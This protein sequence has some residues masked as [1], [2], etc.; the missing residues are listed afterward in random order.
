MINLVPNLGGYR[1]AMTRDYKISE[2]IQVYKGLIAKIMLLLHL[3]YTQKIIDSTGCEHT[4]TINK[5]SKPLCLA[6]QSF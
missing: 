5:K 6:V 3:A 1:L 4:L 2:S